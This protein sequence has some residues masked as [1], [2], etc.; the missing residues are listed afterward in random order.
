MKLSKQEKIKEILNRGTTDIVVRKSLEKR[1][2]SGKKLRIKLGIDPT[3]PKLH[4]GRAVALLKLKAFQELGHKIVFIIG[5]YT[6][7]IGDPS[8]KEKE[9]PMLTEDQ[10]MKNMKLYQKQA[11][12]LLDINQ[13]EVRYN[14]EWHNNLTQKQTITLASKFTVSQMTERDNFSKRIQVGKPVWLHELLYPQLQGY[15]SVMVKAD[16]EIGGNDQLFNL[17]AGREIQRYYNQLE[18]DVLT[19][20]LI[21]GTD[22]RKMSASYGNAIWLDDSPENMYGKVMSIRDDLIIKYLSLCTTMPTDNIRAIEKQLAR[23]DNPREAKA[24]LA[25]EIT[26][27]YHGQKKANKAA[28]EFTNVFKKGKLPGDIP[29]IVVKQKEPKIIDVVIATKFVS[30]RSEARRLI[31]QGAIKVDKKI[32]SNWQQK[33]NLKKDS[34]I[35]V[36]KRRFAKI[37]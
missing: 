11:G 4:V 8:D 30:S 37:K 35:Q 6:A 15:D 17:L 16:V 19:T 21:E 20:E 18:Q 9:R 14:S 2:A 12:L 33:V 10:V 1:L 34:V 26:T 3:H 23:G 29:L 13:T 27:L 31:E 36:G 24:A 22:G 25:K 5:D 28:E 32:I 7:Q